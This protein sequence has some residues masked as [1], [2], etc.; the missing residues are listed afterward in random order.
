[1]PTALRE[2]ALAAI[3]A[4]L[5]TNTTSTVERARRAAVDTKKDTLPHL[6]LLGGDLSDD[7][8]AEPQHTHT[9]L[10]F[11]VVG[12]ARARTDLAADQALSELHAATVAAL[13][14]WEPAVAGMDTPIHEGA[15]LRLL[16]AEESEHPVGRFEARFNV[17]IVAPT[18][19][20]TA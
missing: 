4:R 15:E 3:A 7:I 18:G 16:D 17:L 20:L 12:H 10:A 9:T 13:A 19:T 6:N 11:T 8:T 1:M 5:G 14:T 2:L